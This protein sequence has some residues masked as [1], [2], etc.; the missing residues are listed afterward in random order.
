MRGFSLVE[1]LVVIGIIGILISL[2]LPTLSLVQQRAKEVQCQTNLRNIWFGAQIH[3]NDHQGYLPIGGWHWVPTD[4]VVNPHGLNDDGQVRYIYYNDNGIT[5]PVPVTVAL[6]ISLGLHVELDS[7]EHLEAQM[8]GQEIRK[9]FQ[10]PSQ[11]GQLEG[12]T[13]SSSDWAAPRDWSSY[14]FNEALTGMRHKA[15]NPDPPMGKAS[16]IRQPGSVMYAMDGRPRDQALDNWLMVPDE[17]KEYTVWD[18]HET[19]IGSNGFGKD[20]FDYLRHRYRANV[21][22]MDGHVDSISMTRRGLS[23]VGVSKGLN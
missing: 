6:A 7:R 9:Y 23:A 15:A 19:M 21:L 12:L 8:Q 18:F 5:R 13:Q 17:G 16:R 2:L 4:G 3:M 11:D 14:V 22:F 20:L 1:L 10:C